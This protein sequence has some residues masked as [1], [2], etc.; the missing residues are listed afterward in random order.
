M[1]DDNE[2]DEDE[3]EDDDDDDD[4]TAVSYGQLHRGK[5]WL[6]TKFQT[7]KLL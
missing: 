5:R 7:S 4:K 3:E 2:E 1:I 6:R